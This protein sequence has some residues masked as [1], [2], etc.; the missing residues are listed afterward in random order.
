MKAIG[1]IPETWGP[2]SQAWLLSPHL[3]GLAVGDPAVHGDG[4]ARLAPTG[5]AAVAGGRGG[6]A[7][8]RGPWVAERRR[9]LDL[10]ILHDG[11]C[12]VPGE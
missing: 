9:S 7:G 5:A 3:D 12:R 8:V 4:G 11:P 10:L 1:F 2:P 6:G